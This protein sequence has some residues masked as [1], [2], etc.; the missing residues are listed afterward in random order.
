LQEVK[1]LG[2]NIYPPLNQID[3]TRSVDKGNK[4]KKKHDSL[5]Y[6]ATL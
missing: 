2:E 5:E 1:R 4:E 6:K 3:K